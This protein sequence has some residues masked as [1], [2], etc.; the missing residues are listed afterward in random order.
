MGE[1]VTAQGPPPR[2]RV[3]SIDDDTIIR[4]ALPALLADH[5][6]VATFSDVETFLSSAVPCDVVL[7]DLQLGGLGSA[8]VRHGARGVAAISAAGYRVLIFTGERRPHVLVGCVSNGAYGITHKAEPIE[9]L[10]DAISRVARGEIVVTTALTG[11]VELA[12][13]NGGLPGLTTR[14]T[15]VLSARARGEAYRSIAARLY[16]S[17]KTVEEHMAEV[18]RKFSDYLTSHSPTDLETMLGLGPGDLLDW[19]PAV[20]R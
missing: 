2:V 13:R 17:Q 20:A 5:D 15:E 12:H 4:A 18:T 14:Q 6:V 16:L 19:R 9:E 7:L 8:A 11:L 1:D 10:S 3:C